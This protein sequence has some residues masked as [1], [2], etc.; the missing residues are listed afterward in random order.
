[1]PL[2][3]SL[4]GRDLAV[5]E[6]EVEGEDVDDFADAIGDYHPAYADRT[7]TPPTFPVVLQMKASDMYGVLAKLGFDDLHRVLHGEQE[8]EYYSP[9]RVGERLKL[10]YRV[11]DAVQREGRRGTME[12]ITFETIAERASGERVYTSRAKLVYLPE[13]GME[14]R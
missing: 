3:R 1:M 14:G 8:F 12:I 4:F 2:D 7:A 13:R 6:V 10:R 5:A 9:P 11:V